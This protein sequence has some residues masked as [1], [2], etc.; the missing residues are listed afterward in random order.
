MD[1]AQILE[2][3]GLPIAILGGCLLVV[4]RLFREMQAS[5]RELYKQQ[6]EALTSDRDHYRE[7]VEAADDR[8]RE[9][10]RQLVDERRGQQQQQGATDA[11][12][13]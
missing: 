9:M 11:R 12:G 7:R 4:W 8:A 6:L 10:A 5:M 13:D 2:R 3:V 1:Y